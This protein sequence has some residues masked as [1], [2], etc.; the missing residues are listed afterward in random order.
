MLSSFNGQ[1]LG[2]K[3]LGIRV[4]SPDGS[5][6][7]AKQAW[8]R[9]LARTLMQLTRI[10]GLIDTLMIFSK[11]RTTLHDRIAKTRV[12]RAKA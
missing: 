10:L 8:G 12:V 4:V 7:T 6:V 5:P 2:K 11:P 9:G 1:T 3:A